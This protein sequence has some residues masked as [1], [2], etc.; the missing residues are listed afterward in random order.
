MHF[1][2]PLRKTKCL[3][4]LGGPCREQE[5]LE[6]EGRAASSCGF[7]GSFFLAPPLLLLFPVFPVQLLISGE[8]W[9]DTSTSLIPPCKPGCAQTKRTEGRSKPTSQ[10]LPCSGSSDQL[11]GVQRCSV[12]C[13][14]TRVH[15]RAMRLCCATALSKE[16]LPFP[17]I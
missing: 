12:L 8:T 3:V 7:Q 16:S 11:A 9:R 15:V 13:Q 1:F 4:P 14:H 17:R 5:A 6:P 10:S 2:P